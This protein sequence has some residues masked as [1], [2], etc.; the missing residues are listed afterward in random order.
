MFTGESEETLPLPHI[1]FRKRLRERKS[2]LIFDALQSAHPTR[3]R[4]RPR[5][6]TRL[7]GEKPPAS[8]RRG[9]RPHHGEAPGFTTER[10]SASLRRGIRSHYGETSTLMREG[11]PVSPGRHSR[12]FR[13]KAGS[14]TPAG[15]AGG[16]R[17]GKCPPACGMGRL[18]GGRGEWYQPT[19]VTPINEGGK[20]GN[21]V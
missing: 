16:G 12:P 2:F 6:V 20:H 3:P 7:T 13:G 19:H 11:L 14:V 5:G 8:P 1:F 4:H 18:A 21:A 10:A 9:R 17:R 15:G